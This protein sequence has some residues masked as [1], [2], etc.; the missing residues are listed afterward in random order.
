MRKLLPI[1]S[2][3]KNKVVSLLCFTLIFAL[4]LFSAETAQALCIKDKKANLRQGPGKHYEKL[5]TVFQY[6]P[7][8]SWGKI[9]TG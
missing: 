8:K 5:W 1:P 4:G 6:M 9:E 7:F 3:R 2:Q